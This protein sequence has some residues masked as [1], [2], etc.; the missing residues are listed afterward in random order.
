MYKWRHKVA[1]W[2][3]PG[4]PRAVPGLQDASPKPPKIMKNHPLGLQVDPRCPPMAPNPQFLIRN[5]DLGPL[6]SY[7]IHEF[8]IK[9]TARTCVFFIQSP[10]T[11]SSSRA[12]VTLEI[13]ARA[14]S[15]ATMR[16]NSAL[17]YLSFFQSHCALSKCAF[18][19]IGLSSD[20][21]IF[22]SESL[23]CFELYFRIDS[24]H[25]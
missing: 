18:E 25:L 3:A 20:L 2:G 8:L 9:I 4:V 1:Q 14:C 23:R 6:K 11:S 12:T 13:T 17:T 7:I 21:L 10:C 19:S 15:R 16:S 5:I 24:A 22:S